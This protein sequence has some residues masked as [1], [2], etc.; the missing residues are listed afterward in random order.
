MKDAKGHGSDSRGMASASTAGNHQQGVLR[1][2]RP[3]AKIQQH[4]SA[5]IGTPWRTVQKIGLAGVHSVRPEAKAERVALRRQ[6]DN[7]HYMQRNSP[8]IYTRVRVPK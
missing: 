2:G 8:D 5:L 6:A 4:D 3:D 1:V 7:R